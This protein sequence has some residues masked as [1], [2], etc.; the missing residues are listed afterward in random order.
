MRT[1]LV[2]G[3]GQFPGAP[4][5]P[6]AEVVRALHRDWRARFARAGI[7]LTT[8]VLPVVHAIGPHLD[9]LVAREKPD[10]VVHIGL[11]GSRRRVSVETR[12]RNRSTSLKPDAGGRNSQMALSKAGA[13][14]RR[15]LWDAGRLAAALRAQRID[16]AL[17][18]DAGDYICNAALWHS[19]RPGAVP[20]I[21]IHVPKKRRLPP[22][23][24]AAA[25]AK[26]LPS[27][28]PAG[29]RGKRSHARS[30]QQ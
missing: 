18:N 22:S 23:R 27:V 7:R 17:S 14:F 29:V 12:A 1:L 25:L 3:F 30:E 13:T 2:T 19:L 6:S 16:A 8:A 20:A 26:A 5:N 15:C 11:A 4:Q 9:A 10:A 24:L 28:M 21:F